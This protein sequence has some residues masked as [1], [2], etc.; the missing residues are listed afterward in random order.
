MLNWIHSKI[1]SGAA[2]GLTKNPKIEFLPHFIRVNVVDVSLSLFVC[3][4]VC[5]YVC[6]YVCIAM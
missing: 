2:S 4:H 6:M 3:M 1:I 5:M